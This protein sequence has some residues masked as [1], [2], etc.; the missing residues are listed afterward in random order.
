[1]T[2]WSAAH[3]D[4]E[5][6]ARLALAA[7]FGGLLGI[8]SRTRP[9][10]VRT[11]AMVCAGAALFSLSAVH[12]VGPGSGELLRVI[13]GVAGGI[14]FIGAATVLKRRDSIHGV[15]VAASIWVSGAAGCEFGLGR[16]GFAV[17]VVILAMGANLLYDHIERRYVG[18]RHRAHR[19]GEGPVENDDPPPGPPA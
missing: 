12:V 3:G 16:A 18:P 5:G 11:H 13:Q 7:L 4:L 9:G 2:L 14:G 10:G 6:L 1:M 8:P 15:S 19:E 17:I